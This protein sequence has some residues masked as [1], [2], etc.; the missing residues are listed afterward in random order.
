MKLPAGV[1]AANTKERPFEARIKDGDRRRS[2]GYFATAEE[3]HVAYVQAKTA[4]R[5]RYPSLKSE[6]LTATRIRELLHYDPETGIFTRLTSTGGMHKGTTGGRTHPNG[7]QY[8]RVDGQRYLAHRI[9]WLYMTGAFP[10]DSIDH[11]NGSRADNRFCNLRPATY[12]DNAQNRPVR[13]SN[14]SGLRGVSWHHGRQ[15]FQARIM[16]GGKAHSLGYFHDPN[17]AHK[18]YQDAKFRLHAFQPI[19]RDL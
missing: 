10:E 19:S 2:L 4:R 12:A 1:R 3:A 18:A 17:E 13:S 14:V 11:I 7:Y 8:I 15:K 16:V 6:S 5:A 9:A